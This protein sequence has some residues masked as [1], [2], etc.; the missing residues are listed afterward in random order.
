MI[1]RDDEWIAVP[2]EGDLLECRTMARIA[3]TVEGQRMTRVYDRATQ[4]QRDGIYIPVYEL[5][6][7]LVDNWWSLLYEPW[8][9]A[10]PVPGPGGAVAPDVMGWMHRHCMRTALSGYAAPNVC[11]FSHGR[12]VGIVSRADPRGLYVHAPV[13]YTE[14]FEVQGNREEL[15]VELAQFIQWVLARMEGFADVRVA[16]LHGSWSAICATTA[17]EAEFCRAA[18]RLGLDPY[19]VSEWPEGVVEWFE[20]APP[21][22]LDSGLVE[23]LLECP[24]PAGVKLG[25]HVA[26]T[27]IVEELGL[28]AAANDF[29]AATREATAFAEGYSLASWVRTGMSLNGGER[30]TDVRAAAEAACGRAMVVQESV[31]P[32]GRILAVAGWKS[33]PGPV[34]ATRSSGVL[35]TIR[36]PRVSWAVHGVAWGDPRAAARHRRAHVG[37]AGLTSVRGGAPGAAYQRAR[38]VRGGRTARRLRRGRSA[39][40]EALRRESEGDPPPNRERWRGLGTDLN[41][42]R[43]RFSGGDDL[44]NWWSASRA[45][46]RRTEQSTRSESGGRVAA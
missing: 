37:A 27:R 45:R 39:S 15:R 11:I 13:D 29:G 20:R 22:W 23:D 41:R 43:G 3:W 31:L 42:T 14:T 6:G 30:L 7:W 28:S 9:F 32:E 21:G 46:G 2:D 38:A 25:Q 34:V 19:D 18:G 8:P 24:D 44:R 35:T 1:S 16:E 33:N 40:G 5:A 26:L 4:S 12:D 36:F 10:G 17:E